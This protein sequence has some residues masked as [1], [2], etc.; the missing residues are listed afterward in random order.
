MVTITVDRRFL[1]RGAH[2]PL[3]LTIAVWIAGAE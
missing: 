2:R 3:N 1:A